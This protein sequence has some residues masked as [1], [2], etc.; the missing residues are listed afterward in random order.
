MLALL[1]RLN[2]ASF[3]KFLGPLLA[4]LL[5]GYFAFH[6]IQGNR[7]ILAWHKLIDAKEQALLK[8]EKLQE[9]LIVLERRVKLLRSSGLSLDMLGEEARAVLFYSRPDEVVIESRGEDDLFKQLEGA[10]DGQPPL[11]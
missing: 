4:C 5:I 6:T 9:E 3:K 7:G 1:T 8:R 10:I 11:H 2:F